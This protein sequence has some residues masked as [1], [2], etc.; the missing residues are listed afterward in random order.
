MTT[1][2]K[3]TEFIEQID[4]VRANFKYYSIISRYEINSKIIYNIYLIPSQLIKAGDKKWSIKYKKNSGN[5]KI[6]EWFTEYKD[7][8][9]LSIKSSM[10]NQLWITIDKE[11][12]S[13]FCIISNIEINNKKV[14]NYCELYDKY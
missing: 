13:K 4:N 9:K 3:I 1:C 14:T 12:F 10:S 5:T 7:G 6:T 8:I 2:S 11:Y